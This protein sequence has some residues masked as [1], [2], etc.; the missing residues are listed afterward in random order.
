MRPVPLIIIT[1][2]ALIGTF[3]LT[4]LAASLRSLHEKEGLKALK[5]FRKKFFYRPIHQFFFPND[6]Y[7][8]LF[9]ATTCAQ[10]LTRF[11]FAAAATLFIYQVSNDPF[12]GELR[13][14]LTIALYFLFAILSFS[15][16]DWIPKILGT[17]FPVPTLQKTAFLTSF[18]LLAVFPFTY[19]FLK[20]TRSFSR[21]IYLDTS[22][23]PES[24]VKSELYSIIRQANLKEEL[25]LN[26]K[27]LITSILAFTGHL[28]R[29]VMVPRV[30]VFGLD[31]TTTIKEAAKLLDIEG[32]S[33]VPV[34][35]ETVD[36][37]VGILMYKDILK[38]Y[39]EYE[40]QGN[41]PEILNAPI[42]SIQKPALYT[43]ETKRI[44]SLLQEFRKNKYILQSLSMNMVVLK[45]L[46]RLKIS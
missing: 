16:G 37:I 5:S 20:I 15:L 29:E 25:S 31:Q 39:M 1:L 41:N 11:I 18:F 22:Q 46:L 34:Y 13:L 28:T 36:N 19:L 45:G 2:V 7:E 40:E 38:K 14:L 9:F 42:S 3:F 4:A 17:K 30:D 35:E 12:Q 43:P 8:G 6:E 33:R 27:K 26:D 32:Y 24:K 44:S 21:N 23:E 10:N